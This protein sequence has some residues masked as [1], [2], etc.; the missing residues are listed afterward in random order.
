MKKGGGFQKNNENELD[1]NVEDELF[2]FGE[3]I[4][5]MQKMSRS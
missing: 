2:N 5:A 3:S 4:K 1:E